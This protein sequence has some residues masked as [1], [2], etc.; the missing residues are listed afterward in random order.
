MLCSIP[1][2][3]LLLKTNIIP[4]GKR[5]MITHSPAPKITK[6]NRKEKV[7]LVLRDNKL[8]TSTYPHCSETF[9]HLLNIMPMQFWPF[10][11]LHCGPP[12]FTSFR[13]SSSSILRLVQEHLP[14]H[15]ILNHR[16]VF[17]SNKLSHYLTL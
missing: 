3:P 5:E 9:D 7:D 8:V 11:L 14:E 1:Q 10:Y 13:E 2:R 6:Q 17:H 16:R 15:Q 12:F 4:D